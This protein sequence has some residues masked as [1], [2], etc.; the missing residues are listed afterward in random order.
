MSQLLP[1]LLVAAAR[2][3]FAV[4]PFLRYREPQATA[5]AGAPA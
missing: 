4:W 5:A 3:F 1:V 2:F